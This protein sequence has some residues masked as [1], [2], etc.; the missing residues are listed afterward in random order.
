MIKEIYVL[1]NISD[2]IKFS[3]QWGNLFSDDQMHVY[4]VVYKIETLQDIYDRHSYDEDWYKTTL[5]YPLTID[6][7]ESLE[8]IVFYVHWFTDEEYIL[9]TYKIINEEWFVQGLFVAVK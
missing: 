4:G 7:Y 8:S 6:P 1:P 2:L 5:F 3:N 9:N